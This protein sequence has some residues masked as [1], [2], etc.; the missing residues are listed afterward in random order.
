MTLIDFG[1]NCSWCGHSPHAGVC[2]GTIQ[3]GNA[4]TP[5]TK[6]CPCARRDTAHGSERT[7]DPYAIKGPASPGRNTTIERG[8][9]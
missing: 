9:Q 2:P 5:E 3:T 7:P 4:K 8:Q 1:T 6:P